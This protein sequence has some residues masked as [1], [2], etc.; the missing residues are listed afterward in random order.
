MMSIL[1][2]LLLL[3][4]NSLAFDFDQSF[5]REVED[6]MRDYL[7]T[8]TSLS[9]GEIEELVGLCPPDQPFP[10]PSDA[11]FRSMVHE[12]VGDYTTK[13]VGTSRFSREQ[14][15]DIIIFYLGHKDMGEADCSYAGVYSGE[16]IVNILQATSSCTEI[17][18]LT[19]EYRH[20]TCDG[21]YELCTRAGYPSSVCSGLKEACYEAAEVYYELCLLDCEAVVTTTTAPA[22]TT[23]TDTT[24]TSTTPSTTTTTDTTTT[25]TTPATTTTITQCVEGGECP[26]FGA[27]CC[28]DSKLYRCE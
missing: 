26:T 4:S 2:S 1:L 9:D 27:T 18:D 24:T 17:C 19:K 25:S 16:P 14:V 6:K 22:T 3:I 20:E 15:S 28:A 21:R 13:P 23:T 12:V 7:K 11:D 8:Y 10:C 5:D